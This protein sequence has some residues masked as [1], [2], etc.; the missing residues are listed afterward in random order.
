M[1][2]AMQVEGEPVVLPAKFVGLNCAVTML[3]AI[4]SGCVEY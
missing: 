4:G 3:I 1:G 2:N